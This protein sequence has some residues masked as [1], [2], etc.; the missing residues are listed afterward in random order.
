M[1]SRA[2][3]DFNP[4][5]PPMNPMPPAKKFER[6]HIGILGSL[7]KTN[8]GHEY[9][10]LCVDAYSRWVEVFSMKSQTAEKC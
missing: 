1:F 3:S 7:Y 8:E 5:K 6:W 2:K 9:I 4:A 10:L